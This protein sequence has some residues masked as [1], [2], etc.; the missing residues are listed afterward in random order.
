MKTIKYTCDNTNCLNNTESIEIS[1]WI[2]IG[3]NNNSLYIRSYLG[4]NR[5]KF[6]SNYSDIHFCSSECLSDF[7]IHKK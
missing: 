7:L 3:S 6:A 5:L 4:N 2:E 1:K